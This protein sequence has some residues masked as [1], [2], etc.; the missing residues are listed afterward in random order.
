[1]QVDGLAARPNLGE[2]GQRVKVLANHFKVPWGLSVLL[3]YSSFS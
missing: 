1:M 2:A 3:I